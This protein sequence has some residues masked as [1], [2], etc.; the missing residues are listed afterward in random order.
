MTTKFYQVGGSVRNELYN[1]FHGTNLSL[2]DIDFAV[3][4][5]S[6]DTMR[7]ALISD[8]F[9]IHTETPQYLTIRCRVPEGH[10]LRETAK[11]ADFTLCRTEGEYSDGRHPDELEVGSIHTDLS[12]R[13]FTMNA[14]AIDSESDQ[15]LDPHSG[16]ADLQAKVIRCVGDPWERIAE[17]DSLRALRALRFMCVL[18]MTLD[19]DLADVINNP[20]VA[21]NIEALPVE[22][23][24]AELNTMFKHNTSKALD[25]F[26]STTT[27]ALRKSIFRDNLWLKATTEL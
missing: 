10:A 9:V 1:K 15:I 24:F 13:D 27:S 26:F 6:Y 4:T 12:R 11:D 3:E 14:I 18:D 8:G 22:R 7:E 16:I 19:Q 2:K 20:M 21:K 23:I 17:E 5:A 25:K